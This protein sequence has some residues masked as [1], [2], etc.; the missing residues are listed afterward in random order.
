MPAGRQRQANLHALYERATAYEENGFKG[1]FQFIQFIERLQ[2]QDKD[3]QPTSLENQD[4]ISVMTIH[5]SKGL[6]FPVV[7]LI[8]T[9]RRFNQQDLQRSYVLDNHGG[10]GV[11]YLDSQKRLKV[12]T[13]PE[14]AITAQKRKQLRAEEM[15][16]LYVALTRAEQRLIIVGHCDNQAQL[17]K[18]WQKGQN[19]T[20]QI[21][22]DGVRN[23]AAS[24]LDWNSTLAK[25]LS[26]S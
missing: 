2:K 19:S 18:Q 1:L 24:L 12:P 23:D 7:F 17:M 15:R 3:L 14:L 22:D 8:D 4:A 26:T 10:L 13:L 9:S 20:Q 5:G 16:K 25:S 11:V 6:E 21:L